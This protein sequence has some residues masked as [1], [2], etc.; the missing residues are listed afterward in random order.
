MKTQAAT[1]TPDAELFDRPASARRTKRP[2]ATNAIVERQEQIKGALGKFQSKIAT[3]RKYVS[4]LEIKNSVQAEAAVEALRR[5]RANRQEWVELTAPVVNATNLAHKEACALRS[6]VQKPLDEQDA[7]LARKIASWN[8]TERVRIA[9]EQAKIAADN[10]KLLQEEA[11]ARAKLAR[12][13]GATKK[14]AE[15]VRAEVLA[16][17]LPIQTIQKPIEDMSTRDN[18]SAEVFDAVMLLSWIAEAPGDRI[19]YFE[20]NVKELNICARAQKQGLAIPGVRAR[21]NPS[22]LV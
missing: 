17:P 14:E 19:Q 18:W 12:E 5:I 21:N 1:K 2:A 8:Q 11:D 9:Q 15:Q 22:V 10:R 13:E 3:I 4:D 16:T 20:P 7:F 6:T